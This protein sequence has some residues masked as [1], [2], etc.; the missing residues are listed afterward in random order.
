M[1]I[2]LG[3]IVVL[4]SAC[5]AGSRATPSP[6]PTPAPEPTPEPTIPSALAVSRAEYKNAWPF[7]VDSGTLFCQWSM[8]LTLNRQLV[9]FKSGDGVE[10]ALNGAAIDF[11]YPKV[12]KTIVKK[13]PNVSVLQPLID[14][15]LAICGD[16]P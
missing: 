13:Y 11:G 14:D 10:Y 1:R 6:R 5:G 9:T 2:A 15:G 12:D 16:K 7:T 3:L 4:V 8:N